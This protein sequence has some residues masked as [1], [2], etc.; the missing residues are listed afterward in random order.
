MVI[1][2]KDETRSHL[3]DQILKAYE[4][5]TTPESCA[6]AIFESFLD[7][8][9][10]K[11]SLSMVPTEAYKNGRPNKGFQALV[12]VSNE[13]YNSEEWH[14]ALKSNIT[15]W[16]RV[17]VGPHAK[18]V[19]L[20]YVKGN[21]KRKLKVQTDKS[22]A[23]VPLSDDGG[24]KATP[25]E[26]D[27]PVKDIVTEEKEEEDIPIPIGMKGNIFLF[28]CVPCKWETSFGVDNTGNEQHNPSPRVL[29]NL[30]PIGPDFKSVRMLLGANLHSNPATCLMNLALELDK[31]LT[32][33]GAFR[34]LAVETNAY[35]IFGFQDEQVVCFLRKHFAPYLV[36]TVKVSE[37]L[38]Q[39][40]KAEALKM[41]KK[42][43]VPRSSSDHYF[44]D[45]A[46]RLSIHVYRWQ[47]KS[48]EDSEA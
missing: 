27:M 28:G 29:F 17:Y 15:C 22:S 3:H 45:R 13:T 10:P 34:K 25:D 33:Q 44:F 1:R 41:N 20:E 36:E 18:K 24:E 48:P 6:Q 39:R 2:R 31:S 40:R 35:G 32:G 21:T 7:E 8:C 38:S 4:H 11:P 43:R 23:R 42:V 5:E 37:F 14:S 47:H 19:W 26:G 46:C 9:R 12:A 30:L 16:G